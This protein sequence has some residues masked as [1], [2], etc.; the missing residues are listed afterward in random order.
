MC[1]LRIVL[2]VYALLVEK[3]ASGANNCFQQ[4]LLKYDYEAKS[5]LVYFESA[6]LKWT[7]KNSP[8]PTQIGNILY[9]FFFS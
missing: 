1:V 3:D 5:I 2:F 6:T 7:K 8:G 9:N 4:L